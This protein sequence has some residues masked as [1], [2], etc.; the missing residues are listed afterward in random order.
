[1]HKRSLR[2]DWSFQ[3]FV[4]VTSMVLT[5]P[6]TIQGLQREP[7]LKCNF[8]TLTVVLIIRQLPQKLLLLQFH[9]PKNESDLPF[10]QHLLGQK[11][12]D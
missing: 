8:P 9:L 6:S 12:T 5:P 1:M 7:N 3:E 11:I 2:K 4:Q 10:P